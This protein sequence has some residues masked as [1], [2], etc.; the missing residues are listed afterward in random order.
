M[1]MLGIGGGIYV[2]TAEAV[3]VVE[4][5]AVDIYSD[6]ALLLPFELLLVPLL[7]L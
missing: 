4:G 2:G 5:N 3:T 6:A 7:L 1:G